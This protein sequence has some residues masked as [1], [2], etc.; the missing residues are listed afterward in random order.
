MPLDVEAQDVDFTGHTVHW[1]AT[2]PEGVLVE[3]AGGTLTVRGTRG[4]IQRVAVRAGAGA[5]SGRQR[6][7]LDFRLADGTRLVPS[8]VAVDIR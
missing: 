7:T 5:A 6:I 3:P 4:G 8:E 1:S 2:A